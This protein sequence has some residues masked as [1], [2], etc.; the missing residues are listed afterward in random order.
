MAV[1]GKKHPFKSKSIAKSP[2]KSGVYALYDGG[3]VIYFGATSK[4][5]QT[6]LQRHLHGYEGSCTQTAAHYK[7]ERTSR[8]K[9]K[10][11]KLL[12][13]YEAKHENL[14]PCNERHD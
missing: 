13:A 6:R 14:P 3:K 5:I 12:K 4:S 11:R 1:A 9:R 2:R 7:F 8:P 10:E